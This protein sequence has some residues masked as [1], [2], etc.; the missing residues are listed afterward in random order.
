MRILILAL[1]V[2]IP[3]LAF[4]QSL[5]EVAKKEKERRDKNKQ[6][7]KQ[8]IVISEAELFPE[9]V[10]TGSE[11]SEAESPSAAATSS[12]ARDTRSSRNEEGRTTAE[13]ER[14][15]YD[16]PDRIPP[17]APLEEKLQIFEN[18]KRDYEN[19]VNEIDVQIAENQERIRQL[20]AQI[21]ATSAMGGGGLPVAPVTGTGAERTPMTGQDSQR[22]LGEQEKLRTMNERMVARKEALKLDLQ[23]KGRVGGIPPGYLRF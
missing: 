22:L 6:A 23:T 20:E 16:V 19:K 2:L 9:P 1:V 15:S 10:D 3:S 13:D 21:A 14:E 7:G 17:D 5:A 11:T 12:T 18:M 4:G 8:V